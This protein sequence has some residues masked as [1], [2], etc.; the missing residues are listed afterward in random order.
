MCDPDEVEDIGRGSL[1]KLHMADFR[2]GLV[3]ECLAELR[4]VVESGEPAATREVSRRYVTKFL[5]N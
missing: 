1:K 3:D 5:E 2:A 4:A